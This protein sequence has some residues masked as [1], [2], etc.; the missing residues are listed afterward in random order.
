M[1]MCLKAQQNHHEYHSETEKPNFTLIINGSESIS[2]RLKR[3]KFKQKLFPR[4]YYA[5]AKGALQFH[6]A[7][8]NDRQ[9]RN[10]H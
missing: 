3:S 6:V 10:R 7:V 2:S 5:G 8:T 4:Y 1:Y 9:T